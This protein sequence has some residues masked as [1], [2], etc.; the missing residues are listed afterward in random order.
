MS[1]REVDALTDTMVRSGETLDLSSIPG[2]K[3]D[4]HSTGGVGDKTSL[5]AAPI[6]AAAGVIVPMISGRSLGHTGGTLDKLEAI[7]GFRTN[8][9]LVEFKDVLARCGLALIGQTKEIAPADKKLYALR[10]VTATVQFRPFICASIMSKKLAEGIDGLVLDVKTG[11]GAFMQEYEE[12]RK[13]A[14]S[15]VG[16][17]RRMGKRVIALITDMNQPLGQWVGNAV[18]TFEAIEMLQGNLTGDFAELSLELAAQMIV[19]GGLETN[20]DKARQQSRDAITSGA[21]MEKFKAVIEAQGGNPR[22]CDD[23]KL[24][25]QAGKQKTII[26]PRSGFIAGIK[27]DEIGRIVMEWGGG[28]RRLEDKID[29][30]I[31]FHIHAKLGHEVKIGEPLVTAYFND[32]SKFEEM[33]ARVLKAYRIE[34][35]RPTPEPLIK[36]VI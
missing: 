20:P 19:V 6:A 3:V 17:G 26:A 4:K 24:L 33:Q 10:D 12:S 11:S 18:E 14:E 31:G 13:L 29:Y 36:A 28:R 9:S 35:A 34:E 21:A 5:I 1:D 25:P 7:P 8:L 22:V 30:S 23:P 2:V 16:I 27:T 32:E 15:L